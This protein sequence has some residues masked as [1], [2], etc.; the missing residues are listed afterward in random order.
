MKIYCNFNNNSYTIKPSSLPA[1]QSELSVP[2]EIEVSDLAY[3]LVHG[4]NVRPAAMRGTSDSDFES[5]QLFMV[6]FDNTDR[7]KQPFPPER[8]V[9]P[10]KAVQMASEGGLKPCFGYYTFS[11]TETVPK[12]RLAFLMDRPVT[13]INSRDQIQLAIMQTF[14]DLV[15]SSCKNA[16]RIFFG[17][18]AGS[19]IY[20][21]FDA[22]NSAYELLEREIS[23]P[24]T[25]RIKPKKAAKSGVS[26]KSLTNV[27][28]I[29][30]HDAD[31]LRKRL[32][33]KKETV[34]NNRDEFFNHLYHQI[35]I[36]ELL[37]VKK[38]ESFCCLFHDDHNPSASVFVGKYGFQR[39][40]CFS[41]NCDVESLNIHELIEKIAGFK[42][43]YQTIE[44]IKKA[45]GLSIRETEWSKEQLYEIDYILD[46]ISQTGDESFSAKCPVASKNTRNAKELFMQMLLI[47]RR[48]IYPD[49]QQ[50][51]NIIFSVSVRQIAG[52]SGRKDANK[53]NQYISMLCYH[54]MIEKV[55]DDEIPARQLYLARQA[56][57]G[58]HHTSFYRLTSW[59]LGQ[60]KHIEA[61]GLS[62]REHGYRLK[63]INYQAFLQAEGPEV[64]G[65][66][67][68][69][70]RLKDDGTQR[71][72]S[73]SQEEKRSQLQNVIFDLIADHGFCTEQE[74]VQ[75]GI[76]DSVLRT[77]LVDVLNANCLKKVRCNKSMKSEYGI[78]AKGYPFI[79]IPD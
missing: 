15:D 11:H 18:Q 43:K 64:A 1:V 78:E 33:I 44:F 65:R 4:R 53:T 69:Q 2:I 7:H 70:Y 6:D 8:I 45:Y 58:K 48:N 72:V 62:W 29:R 56:S 19:L 30:N 17:S 40:K 21:D 23:K 75:A 41:S 79:I 51:G 39:Y 63:G 42:T 77:N 9:S 14:G 55:P 24:V 28:L 68:P 47:A 31:G 73:Q 12:F 13:D 35:S 38:G 74:I 46:C 52:L 25:Q 49:I 50:E 10:E 71:T 61:Q 66:I 20:S 57:S 3:K 32:G 5:Q 27:E 59:T 16:S 60:L 36:S 37:G 67:Y 76:S 22:L 34:F 54:G 26:G